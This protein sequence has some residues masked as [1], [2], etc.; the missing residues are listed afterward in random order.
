LRNEG[1]ASKPNRVVFST[2]IEQRNAPS[3]SDTSVLDI[4]VSVAVTIQIYNIPT[5]LRFTPYFFYYKILLLR[6]VQLFG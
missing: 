4:E 2:P 6:S 1:S 3:D 5:Q